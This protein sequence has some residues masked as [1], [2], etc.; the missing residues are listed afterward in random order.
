MDP[1][2]L[3]R[4]EARRVLPRSAWIE[5]AC[6]AF[7]RHDEGAAVELAAIVRRYR[8]AGHMGWADAQKLDEDARLVLLRHVERTRL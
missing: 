1:R 6:E 2:L 3:E 4:I 7:L 5:R 8:A